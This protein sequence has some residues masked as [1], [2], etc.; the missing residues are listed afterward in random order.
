MTL[1]NPRKYHQIFSEDIP[2]AVNNNVNACHPRR[3]GIAGLATLA[4]QCWSGSAVPAVHSG[5]GWHL[6][7]MQAWQCWKCWPGHA[8]LAMLTQQ[9]WAATAGSAMLAMQCCFPAMQTW[10]C[11]P[12][13]AGTA[14]NASLG[15]A[16]RALLASGNAGPGNAGLAM[17]AWQCWPLKCRLGNAV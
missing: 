13:N 4:C 14:G 8:G 16:G 3:A 9:C 17:L 15:N 5:T 10:Q 1:R 7:A 2:S 12:G 11:R 6:Q